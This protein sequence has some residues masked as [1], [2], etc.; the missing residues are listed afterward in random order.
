MTSRKAA[1]AVTKSGPVAMPLPLS[2]RNRD[3]QITRPAL[4]GLATEVVP[5]PGRFN[6]SCNLKTVPAALAWL[7]VVAAAHIAAPGVI[8]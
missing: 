3:R 4:A 1:I 2:P 7:P 8:N 6:E 5:K